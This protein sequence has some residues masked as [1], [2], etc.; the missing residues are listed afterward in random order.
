MIANDRPASA[1][2]FGAVVRHISDATSRR[3]SSYAF[4]LASKPFT[5]AKADEKRGETQ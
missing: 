5:A 2:G 3:S 1:K 4:V